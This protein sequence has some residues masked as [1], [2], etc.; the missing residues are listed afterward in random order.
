MDALGGGLK[1]AENDRKAG[2]KTLAVYLGV[3]TDNN[4]FIPFSYKIIVMCFE[5]STIIFTAS[6]FIIFNMDFSAIQMILIILLMIGMVISTLRLLQMKEFDRKKI[7]Y[8]NRNHELFGFTLVP[9]ILINSIGLY[10]F[11]FIIL[12]PVTW[13][14]IFNYIFYRDSRRNPKTY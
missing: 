2:A 1:D 10:W 11:L 5:I 3:K 8:I 9:M 7:K 6:L 13:F 4:L 14:I 12:L